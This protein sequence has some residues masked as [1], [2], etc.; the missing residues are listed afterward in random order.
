MGYIKPLFTLSFWF[1]MAPPPLLS[2]FYWAFFVFFSV[3]F[4]AGIICGRIYKKEKDNFVLRFSAKY[5]KNLFTTSGIVGFLLLLFSYERAIFLSSR[6]WF[7][8]WA[9]SFGIWLV[10][11]IKKIKL[12]PAKKEEL[13]RHSEYNKYLPKTKKR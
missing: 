12:L 4:L 3:L 6:F 10:F 13:R 8:V 1:D 2:I 9:V 7:F 11:I 5:L